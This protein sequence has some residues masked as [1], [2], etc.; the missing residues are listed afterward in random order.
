MFFRGA[1][2]DPFNPA[3]V[4]FIPFHPSG[5]MLKPGLFDRLVQ[6]SEV[7]K[8]D[9][10]PQASVAKFS[11]AVDCRHLRLSPRVFG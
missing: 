6:V 1:W 2:L 8:P 4:G 10:I 5:R 9:F 11:S 3:R 7:H